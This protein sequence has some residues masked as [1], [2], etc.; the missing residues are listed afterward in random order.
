VLITKKNFDQFLSAVKDEKELGYDTETTTLNWWKSPWHNI[1]A[2][3]F[4]AQFAT[5]HHAYYLDFEHSDD[6]LTEEYW[7]ILQKELFSNPEILWFI[8]NAKFDLHHSKNHG[9]DFAGTIHCTKAIA[10]VCNNNEPE[11]SLDALATKYLGAPKLD[12]LTYIRENGL[13]TKIK[14][15]GHNDKEEELLHFDRV[16]LAMGVEYGLKDVRL[17][18]DLGKWQQREIKRIVEMLAEHKSY[19]FGDVKLSRV[20]ENECKLTK[21]CYE[22]EREGIRIDMDYTRKA[23][24]HEVAEYKKI[25]TELDALAA[26]HLEEKIDWGS[27]KQLKKIFDALG[28]EYHYTEKGNATFDQDALEENDSEL[29]KLILKY[30]Y[31]HMRAHT[32]FENYIWL[33]DSDGYLHVDFQ[34][35]GT[36]FGRMSCWN[37][38]MQN[39]PKRGDKEEKNYKVRKCF[40]PKPGTFF[41]EKDF[42]GAEYFMSMDYSRQMD[43]V[44]ELNNGLDPH[45]RLGSEM[46]LERDPAKTMQFRILYGGGGKVVGK[47]LGYKGAEA[48]QIGKQK[49]KEYFARV[50]NLHFTICSVAGGWFNGRKITGVAESRGYIYNFFGRILNYAKERAYA[51]F[52][53]LIQSGVGD[54]TKIAMVDIGGN[55]LQN[56]KTKMLLQVHDSIL[57]QFYWDELDLLP[58]LDAAMCRA[59]PHKVLQMRT[60]S[61]YSDTSWADL[62]NEI[63]VRSLEA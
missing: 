54:M 35:S 52:N 58:L 4:A 39:V 21:V 5:A 60:D 32:Y 37:P 38:N 7:A 33:A 61:G 22:M 1:K 59:Y 8:A 50:P 27:S 62:Q 30:R 19:Y 13:L 45:K 10:R 29:A 44:E 36:K 49:K 24:E 51:A 20:Y 46:N 6:K 63:P 28:Q 2:R 48:E 26:K 17:A 15:F 16:P 11:L 47:A 55:L 25:E 14:K 56:R 43:I 18:F 53:G 9:I 23:Y 57:F 41:L 31:H 40:I 3:C 42:K 34:Q 12:I